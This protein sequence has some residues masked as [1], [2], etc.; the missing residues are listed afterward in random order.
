[1]KDSGCA[2]VKL[3][4][5]ITT[6][7]PEM[8]DTTSTLL[9]PAYFIEMVIG[10]GVLAWWFM[11]KKQPVFKHFGKGMLGYALGMAAW[12]LLVLTKPTDLKPLVLVGVV[13]FLLAHIAYAKAAAV[14]QKT[15]NLVNVTIVLLIATFIART[16]FYRSEPY[17]SD[18]GLLFFGL[19]TLPVALY[20]A[21][22]SVSFLPAIRAV[23]DE[24]KQ[25]SLKT[26][27]SIGLTVLYVCS[28]IL[29][30]AKDDG[31]LLINGV[32]MNVAM[33]VLVAKALG[34]KKV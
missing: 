25:T 3:R 27:M 8:G 6:G 5:I 31:L 23:A 29:V 21:T 2:I 14:K 7:E 28:I 16:F 15:N 34:S 12:T 32:V 9:V 11:G 24:M 33:I 17:F 30:S 20:I 13:P 4:I 1:M 10:A 22:I 18:K 26:T 19:Q